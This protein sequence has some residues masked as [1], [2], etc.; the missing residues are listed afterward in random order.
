MKTPTSCSSPSIRRRR[1]TIPSAPSSSRGGRV[2]ALGRNSSKRNAD[3]D[4][5]RRDGRDPRLPLRA[6]SPR[7]SRRTT[8]YA[9]ASRARCAWARSSGAGSA[10]SSTRPRSPSSPRK[11][12]QIDIT[13]A[14]D[15][16]RDAVRRHRD[17]GRAVVRQRDAAVRQRLARTARTREGTKRA[18]A[19]VS[20]INKRHL[21]TS[22]A[23]DLLL[24]L[25]GVPLSVIVLLHLFGVLHW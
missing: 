18:Q 5:A 16:R 21:E 2:L 10:G 13:V 17:R 24:W 14:A 15:R 20:S 3:P 12:G 9:R 7:T 6:M 25:L 19:R 22:M 23:R 1:P 8:L 11:I 4:R